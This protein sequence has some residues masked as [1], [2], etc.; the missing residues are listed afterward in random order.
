M[1]HILGWMIRYVC[2]M[3]PDSSHNT[4][5]MVSYADLVYACGPS[6]SHFPMLLV[7][8]TGYH[9]CPAPSHI[10][11]VTNDWQLPLSPSLWPRLLHLVR[12]QCANLMIALRVPWIKYIA[13][14]GNGWYYIHRTSLIPLGFATVIDMKICLILLKYSSEQTIVFVAAINWNLNTDDISLLSFER[15]KESNKQ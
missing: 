6:T 11:I 5:R 14:V 8:P 12:F 2:T 15:M 13:G 10:I 9:P 4:V 1:L 3:K 7:N